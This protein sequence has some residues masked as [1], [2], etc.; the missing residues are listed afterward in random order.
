SPGTICRDDG[1]CSDEAIDPVPLCCQQT[2]TT[3][4]EGTGSSVAGLWY[5]QYYCLGGVGLGNGPYMAVNAACG[6]DGICVPQ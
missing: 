2:A 4:Y 3:C 6:G 1:T 5:F